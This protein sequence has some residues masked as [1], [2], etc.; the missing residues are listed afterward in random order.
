MASSMPK[1]IDVHSHYLPP[2]YRQHCIDNGHGNPDG[3]VCLKGKID[4]SQ[5]DVLTKLF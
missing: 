4:G 3:M 5:R 1:K 2:L